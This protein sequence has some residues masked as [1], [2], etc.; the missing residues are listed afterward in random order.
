MLGG[1]ASAP[2][3]SG[4]SAPNPSGASV[5]NPSATASSGAGKCEGV[6]ALRCETYRLA[7]VDRVVGMLGAD[8][9]A[10]F[11]GI[12]ARLALTCTGT[13]ATEFRVPSASDVCRG[14]A[15]TELRFR[16]CL[17]CNASH[18]YLWTEFRRQY[19]SL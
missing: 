9:D 7:I 10:R 1:G 5:A 4:A 17:S 15:A 16:L 2:N 8:S 14:A 3:P 18:K 13:G 12:A 11:V 6:A 19:K